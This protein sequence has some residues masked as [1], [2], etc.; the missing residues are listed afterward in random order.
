MKSINLIVLKKFFLEDKKRLILLSSIIL[1]VLLVIFLPPGKESAPIPGPVVTT[2]NELKLV[3][4]TPPAGKREV[5]DSFTQT[6]FEFSSD[7]DE[8]SADVSVTPDIALRIRVYAN[9]PRVLVIEPQQVPWKDGV[10]Y[11][12][13]INK[14]RSMYGD[15]LP[16][17]VEYKFSNTPPTIVEGGD[18]IDF[19]PL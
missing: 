14:L 7:I 9:E 10:E 2:K 6:Y 15:E 8:K 1:I 17:P 13:T 5:P 11:T 3:K 12:I 16:K 4:T 19:N 18:P